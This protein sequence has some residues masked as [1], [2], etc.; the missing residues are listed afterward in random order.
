MNKEA[1]ELINAIDNYMSESMKKDYK[2]SEEEEYRIA[3]MITCLDNHLRML[4]DYELK[5]HLER[6]K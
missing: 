4:R 1:N 3:R 2:F 5:R 6:N